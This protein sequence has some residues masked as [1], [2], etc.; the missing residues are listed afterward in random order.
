MLTLQNFSFCNRSKI[1]GNSLYKV[2]REKDNSGKWY[3]HETYSDGD[4]WVGNNAYHSDDLQ[5]VLERINGFTR[6]KEVVSL[7]F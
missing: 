2:C 4:E 3:I 7:R 1:I 6:E 5:T